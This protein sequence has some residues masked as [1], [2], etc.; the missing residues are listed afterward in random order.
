MNEGPRRKRSRSAAETVGLKNTSIE[1][2]VD[3]GDIKVRY[4]RP[5]MQKRLC[6]YVPA[7]PNIATISKV[8]LS[9]K[10]KDLKQA[11]IDP[12]DHPRRPEIVWSRKSYLTN[13]KELET[14][15]DILLANEEG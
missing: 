5:G 4:S 11:G 13:R 12:I 9:K 3:C 10:W 8:S 6:S 2:Q 15:R 14:R 7:D 1:N